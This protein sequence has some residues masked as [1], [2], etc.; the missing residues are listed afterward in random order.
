[1]GTGG[2]A[3]GRV[4]NIVEDEA[5]FI[6]RSSLAIEGDGTLVDKI[7][8]AD[9]VDPMQVIG[10]FVGHE[11]GV[12]PRLFRKKAERLLAEVGGGIYEDRVASASVGLD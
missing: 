9:V 1:M 5:Y 10:M 4:E 11:D 2:G 6:E 12:E 7:E 8:G 3:G